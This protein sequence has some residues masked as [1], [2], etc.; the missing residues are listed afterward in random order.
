VERAYRQREAVFAQT[1][2]DRADWDQVTHVQRHQAVARR[3]RTA[4]P[5][6]RPGLSAA[7]LRR[8][9]PSHRCPARELTLTPDRPPGEIDQW[10]N[11]LAA[12]HRA[13]ADRLADRQSQ[14]IPSA[15]P[16]YGDLGLAFPAWADRAMEPI[17]QPA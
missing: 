3:L 9:R 6:P 11:D 5:P 8:T 16:D 4:S 7:T 10:I 15:D 13:F 1:M 14:M 17:L 12:G 2:A